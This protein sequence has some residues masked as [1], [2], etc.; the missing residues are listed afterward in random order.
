MRIGQRYYELQ[1]LIGNMSQLSEGGTLG[2]LTPEQEAKLRKAWIH[3][4]R[5]S[6]HAI[7]EAASADTPD[8][9]PRFLHH[10]TDNGKSPEGFKRALWRFVVNDHPDATVLRFL[11]ARK[12]DVELA[13]EMLVSAVN[14]RRETNLDETIVR[15]GESVGLAAAPSRTDREFL[16][17]YR[18]GKSY[19][20]NTDREN[21]PIYIARVRM[22][23]PGKQGAEAME[24]YILHSIESLRLLARAPHDKACL[25]FDMAGFGLKNM[26]Y[27]VAKFLVHVFEARYPET[28]GAVLVHNAPFVFWGEFGQRH[29]K[30]QSVD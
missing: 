6:G 5:L 4:L 12:W 27:H 26:D 17:Q 24:R 19:A 20:R 11:R 29:G 21:R 22:H 2:N 8:Q 1:Q 14:W 9:S 18:S 10:L 13:V 15:A 25:I 3:L 28:L 7:P 23:D 30:M 16:D